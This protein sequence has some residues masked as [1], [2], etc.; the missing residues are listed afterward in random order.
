MRNAL[1]LAIG[2]A[3]VMVFATSAAAHRG[4][5][6]GRGFG[7]PVHAVFAVPRSPAVFG[8]GTTVHSFVVRPRRQVFFSFGVGAPVRPLFAVPPARVAPRV[9][10]T[11][12]PLASGPV[13]VTAPPAGF[14]PQAVMVIAPR[15]L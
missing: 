10:V 7:T 11:P 8:V 2:L 6:F 12:F 14:V 3:A 9:I 1:I 15:R 5:F 4:A 13:I